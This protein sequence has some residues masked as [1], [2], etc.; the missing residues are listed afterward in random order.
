MNNRLIFILKTKKKGK[1]SKVENQPIVSGWG[2]DT[3]HGIG[4]KSFRCSQKDIIAR[5][6]EQPAKRLEVIHT[7]YR[8]LEEAHPKICRQVQ[9][10]MRC[11]SGTGFFGFTFNL[12][13]CI[14]L[15]KSPPKRRMLLCPCGCLARGCW[16]LVLPGHPPPG[17]SSSAG[18]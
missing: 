14:C 2:T 7:S 11:A 18:K 3:F 13:T 12:A 8:G 6:E 16:I 5:G 1:F 4:A 15:D 10:L 9:E 17:D